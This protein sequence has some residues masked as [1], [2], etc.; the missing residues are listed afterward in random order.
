MQGSCRNAKADV[1]WATANE[2]TSE[3]AT[4]TAEMY[5]D[6]AKTIIVFIT[7]TKAII[8]HTHSAIYT[9]AS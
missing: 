6:K 4:E 7:L 9:G 5:V 8:S 3:W 2:Q 1:V